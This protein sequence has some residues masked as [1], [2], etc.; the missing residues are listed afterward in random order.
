MALISEEMT[1]NMDF[2]TSFK[3]KAAITKVMKAIIPATR[4]GRKYGWVRR[5][6]MRPRVSGHRVAGFESTPPIK[7][8]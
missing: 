1:E 3:P 6:E 8:L 5:Y 7:G 4:Q 2:V